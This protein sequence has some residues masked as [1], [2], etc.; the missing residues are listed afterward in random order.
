MRAIRIYIRVGDGQNQ[1][2]NAAAGSDQTL[3]SGAAGTLDGS[4][5]DDGD[6]GDAYT[7]ALTYKWTLVSG[8]LSSWTDDT[9]YTDNATRDFTAPTLTASDSDQT[10]I[11]QLEVR[12]AEVKGGSQLSDATPDNVT[13]TVEAPPVITGSACSNSSNIGQ[14]GTGSPC[15]DMLIVNKAMIDAANDTDS[16]QF[17]GGTSYGG[18][19]VAGTSSDIY[20]FGVASDN[21][22]RDNNTGVVTLLNGAKGIY[23]GQISNFQFLFD[24]ES[25]FN[26]EIN[27]WDMSSG[28]YLAYMFRDATA[29][30]QDVSGWDTSSMEDAR[31]LFQRASA[32]DQNI[33]SWDM[34]AAD[35]IGFIFNGA[36]QFN[37][38]ISAWNLSN[39]TDMSYAFRNASSFDQNISSWD[40]SN[41]TTVRSMFENASNFDQDISGWNLS[42]VTNMRSMFNSAA[43]FNQ[44]VSSWDVSSV[45]D[46]DYMFNGATAFSQNM[47]S[48]NVSSI[49]STPSN[50]AT[51]AAFASNTNLHPR[52]GWTNQAP[53]AAAG[54]DQTVNSGAAGT[55]DGSGSDD[56]DTG[57]AYT[58]ALTYKWTLVSGTLSSWTDDTSYTDNATRDFTAPTM[59]TGDS[60]QTLIFQLDVQEAAVRGGSQL[61]SSDNITITIQPAC[62]LLQLQMLLCLG[63]RGQAIASL[64]EI[65]SQHPG[66]AAHQVITKVT[67]LLYR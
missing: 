51:S 32:F 40:M 43:Q 60:A 37:Q 13:I 50:F 9:S 54:S 33:S 21:Y 36:T 4:G 14:I 67:L 35:D 26:E 49:S 18:V 12:E 1:A 59:S 19:T 38:D 23:T 30:N 34:S 61:S 15:A 65:M 28:R 11:F 6:T 45:T 55:L 58:D 41:V 66:I 16:Y 44:D 27:Y 64:L 17:V 46:F 48:W 53:N 7:D 24:G 57:D 47:A 5:S 8:T 39:V 31:G 25:S 63:P 20:P 52:W 62:L 2:P 29:F 42:S 10:L 22:S 3:S 56:G